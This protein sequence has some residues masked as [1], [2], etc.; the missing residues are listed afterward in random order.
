MTPGQGPKVRDDSDLESFRME[1]FRMERGRTVED[2]RTVVCFV[3][4]CLFGKK[5][6]RSAS[7]GEIVKPILQVFT[8]HS[9]FFPPKPNGSEQET[10]PRNRRLVLARAA[11]PWRCVR[12]R[13]APSGAGSFCLASHGTLNRPP[14]VPP[15]APADHRVGHA[16]AARGPVA[17]RHAVRRITPLVRG[18]DAPFLPGSR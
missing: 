12:A 17:V 8:H 3:L 7:S 9:L 10:P 6:R 1:S 16:A 2:L 18:R 15:P 13:R 4:F 5:V 14:I 11:P